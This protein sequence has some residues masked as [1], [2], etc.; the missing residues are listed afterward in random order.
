MFGRMPTPFHRALPRLGL[1]LLSACSAGSEDA[2]HPP[3]PPARDGFEARTAW[4]GFTLVAPLEAKTVYLA[5]M[6]GEA[7]HTWPSDYKTGEVCY[8]T[9]RGTLLKSQ[10]AVDHPVFQDAGGHGGRIQE[11]DWDGSVLWDF[12]WD[13]EKGLNHH[14]LEELPNGNVLFIAWDRITRAEALAAGRDPELLEGEEFWAGAIYEV[15][16]K[17][18]VGGEIVWSWHS[19]DH[20]VQSFDETLPGYGDPSAHPERIDINGDRDPD[21][22][23]EEEKKEI[24]RDIAALGYG[25]AA[26]SDDDAGDGTGTVK[27]GDEKVG[28]E[29]EEDPED[30]ARK[31]RVKDADWMHTNAVAYNADLDQIAISVRRF[32]E[33]WIIDHGVTREEAAGPRGDLLYRWGNP[34]SYGMGNWEDRTL[35]G[36]HD[37][38]WIPEGHLGAGNLLV[39]NNGSRP[40]KWSS[41]DEWWA[42][43]DANGRYPRAVGEPWKPWA[44]TWSWPT[45]E[46]EGFFAR[47][48]SGVQRLPNGNTLIC[49]GPQGHVFEITKAGDVVWDWKSPFRPT[50]EELDESMEKYPTA[51]FRALRYAADSPNIARL[52]ERGAPVP[53]SAGTGP[54]TNQYEPSPEPADEEDD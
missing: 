44:P 54:A 17:R 16:P 29:E 14:D 26:T 50:E 42:P 27:G 13:S 38:Q 40:R 19:L 18:P 49:A 23:D 8:L 32:D 52:R 48:I 3:G 2:G 7:V 6:A 10:R 9:E 41:V 24:A 45:E 37:V 5:D 28:E 34:Y 36:Q 12:Q 33:I 31:A 30:A 35:F 46:R 43:R 15:A 1:A 22:P 25:A 11:I 47:F 21:P 4:P 51:I 53:M 20:L 39:F